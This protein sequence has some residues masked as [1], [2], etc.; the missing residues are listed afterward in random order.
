[1]P[2]FSVRDTEAEFVGGKESFVSQAW[3]RR[4]DFG[5]GRSE[6]AKGG[7][8]V[9]FGEGCFAEAFDL[10]GIKVNIGGRIVACRPTESRF[11]V[12]E[13]DKKKWRRAP[14]TPCPPDGTKGRGGWFAI[15][16]GHDH[17]ERRGPLAEDQTNGPQSLPLA[18]GYRAEL[19]VRE[20]PHSF[21]LPPIG[22]RNDH[23]PAAQL[24]TS[25]V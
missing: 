10:T 13:S 25:P 20:E 19:M 17:F 6:K 12:V 24:L 7:V 14:A 5:N 11:V 23:K 3:K 18:E 15:S 8:A 2:V 16:L 22:P 1:M 4:L 21:S 9:G